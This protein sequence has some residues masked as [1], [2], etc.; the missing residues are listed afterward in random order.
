MRDQNPGVRLGIDGF[1]DLP[2][3]TEQCDVSLSR[4]RVAKVRDAPMRRV[5]R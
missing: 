5:L 1:T 3:G 4:R 2:L